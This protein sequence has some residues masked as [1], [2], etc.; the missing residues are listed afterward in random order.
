MTTNDEYLERFTANSEL[1]NQ[2]RANQP[3]DS[4]PR[5]YREHPDSRTAERDRLEHDLGVPF[6][7]A[8][9]LESDQAAFDDVDMIQTGDER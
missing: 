3:A 6:H 8:A 1:A 5:N 7:N 2:A 4:V 9:E